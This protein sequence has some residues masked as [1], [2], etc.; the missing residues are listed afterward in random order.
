MAPFGP[1]ALGTLVVTLRN[2]LLEIPRAHGM[3]EELAQRVGLCQASLNAINVSLDEILTNIIQHGFDD[4]N[5]HRIALRVTIDEAR[6][7]TVEVEDDGKAF[8]PLDA[9]DPALDRSIEERPIG[10]LGIHLVKNLMDQVEYRRHQGRN[11]LV[12]RRL[13]RE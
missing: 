7:A 6:A 9:P 2:D 4:T 13:T 10:G 5:E 12:F 3:I 8:N 11:L 1:P